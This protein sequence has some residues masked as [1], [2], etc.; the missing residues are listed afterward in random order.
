MA[1]DLYTAPAVTV[2]RVGDKGMEQKCAGYGYVLGVPAE[3]P[4][5]WGCLQG[6]N[7]GAGEVVDI[8]PH[9]AFFGCN[10]ESQVTTLTLCML[11]KI[12]KYFFFQNF[13]KSHC[14]HPFFFADIKSEC[15]TIWISDSSGSKLFA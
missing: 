14:F 7:A 11:G 5:D 12:F 1:M 9:Y 13:Q 3:E 2:T 4:G 15:Q 8:D 10:T 6:Y